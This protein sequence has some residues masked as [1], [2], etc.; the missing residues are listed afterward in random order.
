MLSEAAYPSRAREGQQ[1][2]LTLPK[3]H[4]DKKSIALCHR[5]LLPSAL[6]YMAFTDP[7]YIPCGGPQAKASRRKEG[8]S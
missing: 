1:H 2:S 5:N 8:A 7:D 6:S 4:D 3:S